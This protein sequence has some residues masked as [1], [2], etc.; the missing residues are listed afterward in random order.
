MHACAEDLEP[1]SINQQIVPREKHDALRNELPNQI[2]DRQP[3]S[4]HRPFGIGKEPMKRRVMSV[5][6]G[7]PKHSGNRTVW[8]EYPSGKQFQHALLGCRRHGHREDLQQIGK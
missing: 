4:I 1:P 7:S 8:R 2:V 3:N 6:A 5:G